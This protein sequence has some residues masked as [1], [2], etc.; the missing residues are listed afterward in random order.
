MGSE[1]TEIDRSATASQPEAVPAA[2][3][4]TPPAGSGAGAWRGTDRRQKKTPR[5]SRWTFLGGRRR[6]PRRSDERDGAFVDQYGTG[7]LV[8]LMWIALANVADCF[9]TLVHL[10]SGGAEVNPVADLLLRTGLLN[11]VLLKSGLVS[12]ALLV[13][14]LHKNLRI[15]KIGIWGAAGAYAILIVYHLAL[16]AV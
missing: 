7:L 5:L 8:A 1:E 11:F 16:F 12:L 4:P 10:Q 3:A 6:G 15:A 2:V 13:L 14:C 9:F